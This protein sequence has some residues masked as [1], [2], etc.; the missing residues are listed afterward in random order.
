M[1]LGEVVIIIIS[2]YSLFKAPFTVFKNATNT[3]LFHLISTI[4]IKDQ[5]LFHTS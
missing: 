1:A 5:R 2:I 3:R 4:S